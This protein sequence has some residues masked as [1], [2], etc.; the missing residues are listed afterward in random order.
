MKLTDFDYDL[1]PERIAQKPAD[2]R[3]NSR[4]LVL[5]R[6]KTILEDRVFADIGEYFRPGD[7][8]V[9]NETKV[10]PAR[11]LGRRSGGGKAEVFLLQRKDGDTWEVLVKPGRKLRP[12]S[13]VHFGEDDHSYAEI[14]DTTAEGGRLATFHYEGIW[15]EWLDR[16]GLVP[17]PP[18]IHDYDGDLERYQTVYARREGSVAAPTAGLHFTPE[19]LEELSASGVQILKVSLNVGIG[20]FRPVEAEDIEDHVMHAEYYEIDGDTAAAVNAAKTEGRRVIACGT[21]STRVLESA[22][23]GYGAVTATNGWTD[24]YFYPGY[25][26]KIIDG[27][28]TNFH[29][30][31]S[32]LL[33]L[34]SALAGRERILAAYEHAI[35][36]EYRFFSFGDAMLIL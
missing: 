36:E 35:K 19:L 24:A 23:D 18:Y 14:A 27:L 4:L 12:G 8:L 31:K 2:K 7:V 30:P 20:T 1:P 33:M 9:L 25:R 32:S 3:D 28:I 21:T 6:S 26:Y 11:L 17:L 16:V 34:V 10:I 15:E 13:I 22:A 29:L 5:D